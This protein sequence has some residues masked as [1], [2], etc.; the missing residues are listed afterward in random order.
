[1]KRRGTAREKSLEL[2]EELV[3]AFLSAQAAAGWTFVIG[4]IVLGLL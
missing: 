3:T 1:M 4:K 2:K